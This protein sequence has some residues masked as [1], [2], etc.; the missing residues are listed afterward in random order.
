MNGKSVKVRAPMA[1]Q[2]D[3]PG[4]PKSEAGI[5]TGVPVQDY[6][7][8]IASP[9][10]SRLSHKVQRNLE[11]YGWQIAFKKSLAYL[12]RSLY[13]QQVYR[14]YRIELDAAKLPQDF[15]PLDFTFKILTVQNVGMIAEVENIAEWLRGQ[16]KEKIAAGQLCLV[17]LDGDKVAGFNLINF[18]QATLVLVNLQRKL[19]QGDAWSEHIAVKKEFRRTGLGSQL[20]YRIFEELRKRGFRKLYGGTLRSNTA[21]LKLTRS[22]GFTEI[23]DIHYRKLFSFE[24]WRYERFRA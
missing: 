19:R 22:V 4:N 24:K 6:S 7:P 2:R 17:A 23:G 10:L 3:I 11:D 12:L 9:G 5:L 18:E 14:I 13:F 20:R 15:N 8:G 1:E 21:S 16:L